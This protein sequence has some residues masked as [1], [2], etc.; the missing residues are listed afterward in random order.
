MSRRNVTLHPA[1]VQH[2]LDAEADAWAA[3]TDVAGWIARMHPDEKLHSALMLF[4]KQCFAEGFYE[5]AS[6]AARKKP[7]QES[8]QMVSKGANDA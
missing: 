2:A 1:T 8:L 7:I 5:G 6:A 3:T 4:A